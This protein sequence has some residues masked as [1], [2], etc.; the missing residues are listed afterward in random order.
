MPDFYRKIEY[1][2]KQ[3]NDYFCCIIDIILMYKY[4]YQIADN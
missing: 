1:I 3:S 2:M 4:N